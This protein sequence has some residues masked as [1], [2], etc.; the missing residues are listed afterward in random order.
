MMTHSGLPRSFWAETLVYA[1]HLVNRLSCTAIDGKTPL[2]H[3]FGSVTSD[4]ESLWIF[5][6]PAYYHVN[7]GKLNPRARKAVFVGFR[8]RVKGF[9]L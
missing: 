5:G 1:S 7:D 6:C 9:K 4:Y 8:D 3:W 2:E